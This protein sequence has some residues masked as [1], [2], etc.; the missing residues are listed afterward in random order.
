MMTVRAVV[1]LLGLAA[2]GADTMSEYN[3]IEHFLCD[4]FFAE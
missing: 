1:L 2:C 3:L 4:A